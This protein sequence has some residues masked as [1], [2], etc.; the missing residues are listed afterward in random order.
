MEP[1]PER[2]TIVPSSSRYDPDDERW[3]SQVAQLRRSLQQEVGLDSTAQTTPGTKGSADELIVALGTS[4]AITAVVELVRAFLARDRTRSVE[5]TWT[6]ATGQ[7]RTARATADGA[8]AD[9]LRPVVE[10]FGQQLGRP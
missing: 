9:T 1:T 5:M 10:A 3:T 4:G 8:A 2:M 6:D 7:E